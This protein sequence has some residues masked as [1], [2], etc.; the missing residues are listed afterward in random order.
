MYFKIEA[1]KIKIPLTKIYEK[2]NN[3]KTLTDIYKEFLSSSNA[4]INE[5]NPHITIPKELC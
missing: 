1:I 2:L 5:L 3:G 4:Y